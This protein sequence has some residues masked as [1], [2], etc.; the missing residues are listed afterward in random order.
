MTDLTV[1]LAIELTFCEGMVWALNFKKKSMIE[2][3][4]KSFNLQL[5]KIEMPFVF[6]STK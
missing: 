4:Y 5:K 1:L 6:T 3:V 2:N